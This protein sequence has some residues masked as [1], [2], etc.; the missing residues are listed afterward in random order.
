MSEKA[1]GSAEKTSGQDAMLHTLTIDGKTIHLLGTAHV[2]AKSADE[3]EA[4]IERIKPDSVCVELCEARHRSITNPDSFREMDI[5]Q[6]VRK[7]QA[8]M[9]L[10]HLVLSSFQRRMGENLGIKPGAEM[11]RAMEAADRTGAELVLADRDIQITL[12]RTWRQLGWWDKMKLLTHL[13]MTIVSTPKMDEAEIEALKQQDMLSQVMEAFSSAF[14]KAKVTLIDERDRFLAEKIRQAPGKKVVAVVGAGHLKGILERLRNT[15]GGENL[16][17][18]SVVPPAGVG[19]R[20]LQW[21]IPLLVIGLIGYG[22]YSADASVS[23][24]MI[25]IWVL[26]NGILSALGAALALAHPL[27][28][29]VAFLAAPITSLNPMVAAG[30]VAGLCEAVVH[31]PRVADFEKLPEDIVTFRGFWR[32]GITRILLVVALANLGSSIG[33]LVGLPLMSSLLG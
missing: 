20:V 18:I 12:R 29:L 15:P 19:F 14:P 6:V 16:E 11:V 7:K 2:S 28:I 24:E 21:G 32:N 27:T 3:A 1:T 5:I 4:L 25:K 30:W 26:A 31:R 13:A 10:A 23:W 33:T 8:T 17:E 22:F 9:L